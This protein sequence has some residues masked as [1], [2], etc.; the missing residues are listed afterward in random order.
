MRRIGTLV[1][2]AV[3]ASVVA[4]CVTVSHL[5][6]TC[7]V[8]RLNRVDAS[9]F[10][11]TRS[12]YHENECSQWYP[13]HVE[14]AHTHI[15]ERGTCVSE[16][17]LLGHPMSVGCRPGH[18]PI[19]LLDP[20]TQMHVYQHF[21]D[22]L[23]AKKL[24]ES[25]TDAKSF[26]DRLDEHDD[27]RGHLTARA[28]QEWEAVGFPGTWPDWWDQF[29]AQHVEYHKEWLTWLHA[30]SNM[31]FWDWQKLGKKNGE[32]AKVSTDQ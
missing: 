11:L 26:N 10:S 6:H 24:F 15:W 4:S 27:D 29:Y 3:F 13:T 16:T 25:L 32:S 19:R 21:K 30:N 23:E 18:Y 2:F 8:C 5:S 17:N 14:P 1:A 20:T 9:C 7:V 31:N 28:I 22:P 12:T